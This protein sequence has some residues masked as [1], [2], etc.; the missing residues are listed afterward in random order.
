MTS[1][2]TELIQKFDVVIYQLD[3]NRTGSS[4]TESKVETF[5]FSGGDS[6]ISISVDGGANQDILIQ[7]ALFV[8]PS[9]ATAEEVAFQVDPL[10]TGGEV[11]TTSD[12]RVVIATLTRG[13]SGAI[14]VSGPAVAILDISVTSVDGQAYDDEFGGSRPIDDGTQDG[15][16]SRREKE[17]V[18]LKCQISWVGAGRQNIIPGGKEVPSDI[19]ITVKVDD[20]SALGLLD[21][22]NE[23]LL[24]AADRIDRIMRIDGALERRFPNPEG[25]WINMVEPIGYGLAYFGTPQV[26][27]YDLHCAKDRIK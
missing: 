12:G 17:P 6:V 13:D 5:D 7:Q 23:P 26:N 19:V 21:S 2:Y 15:T 20:L 8:D 14:A 18:T 4:S 10:L 11:Y 24:T 16:P 27:L 22:N 1:L 25:M 9:A 3:T